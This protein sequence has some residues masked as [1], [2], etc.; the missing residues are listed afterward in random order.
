MMLDVGR[1]AGVGVLDV[2]RAVPVRH[3]RGQAVRAGVVRER[4]PQRVG[5]G[6]DPAP[7]RA[8]HARDLAHHPGGVLDE[9]DR[10][11]RGERDVEHRRAERQELGVGLYERNVDAGVGRAVAGMA[12]HAGGDVERDRP[13]S[14]LGQ[15]PRTHRGAAAD[16]EHE[17]AGHVAE[18]VRVRF[19]QP[20]R[21]PD[22]IR[23]TEE[24][25][26]RRLVAVRVGVPP[27]PV[28]A[29][30]A[31]R[32]LLATRHAHRLRYFSHSVILPAGP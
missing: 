1:L 30:R 16:L 19:A 10:A 24:R 12:Q 6:E 21:R 9:R 29:H 27:V 15:P 3:G 26:V 23:G 5:R 31:R 13:R 2:G 4:P 17:P 32:V 22:E 18:Q 25:A 7:T 8:Q 11:E 14:G 20:F 28:G